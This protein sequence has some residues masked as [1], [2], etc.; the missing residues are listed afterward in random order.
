[1]PQRSI[2][3]H[4]DRVYTVECVGGR[5]SCLSLKCRLSSDE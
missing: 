2:T 3:Q 5:V 1:L 4:D